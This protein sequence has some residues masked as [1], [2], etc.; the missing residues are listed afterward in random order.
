MK[1]WKA[2]SVAA[3]GMVSAGAVPLQYAPVLTP[4]AVLRAYTA[5][6][7]GGDVL[8]HHDDVITDPTFTEISAGESV[9]S[10]IEDGGWRYGESVAYQN[11]EVLP[12]SIA[13]HGYAG[14]WTLSYP[15]GSAYADASTWMTLEF[16]VSEPTPFIFWSWAQQ[17]R[18]GNA[19][20]E[21]LDA[22]GNPLLGPGGKFRKLH[23]ELAPGTYQIVTVVGATAWSP[24]GGGI[25][26]DNAG[27]PSYSFRLAV[28]VPESLQTATWLG[29][30]MV[31]LGAGALTRHQAVR[32]KSK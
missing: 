17:A 21:L 26:Y 1:T 25:W 8:E 19:G 9:T 30:M 13:G 31:V 32:T 22:G 15:P 16:S 23:G 10:F 3:V 7:D 28:V 11:S 14:A 27:K 5:T 12:R 24:T 29:L 20:A 6:A 2:V 4:G 18:G